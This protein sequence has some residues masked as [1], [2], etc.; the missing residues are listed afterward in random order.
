MTGVAHLHG[1]SHAIG[2]CSVLNWLLLLQSMFSAA[3]FVWTSARELRMPAYYL[4]QQAL[5]HWH[6]MRFSPSTCMLSLSTSPGVLWAA[7][8]EQWE[9]A[10]LYR[11]PV[12]DNDRALACVTKVVV[13][14]YLP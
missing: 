5:Q 3:L 12:S 9:L 2:C 10:E 14:E 11:P 1:D 8:C 6:V 4:L 13:Y 7:S